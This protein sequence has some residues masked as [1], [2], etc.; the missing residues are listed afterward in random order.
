MTR[1]TW[2]RTLGQERGQFS[3]SLDRPAANATWADY[4][5]LCKIRLVSLVLFTTAVGFL[6][7]HTGAMNAAA[8]LL[9]IHTVLGTALVACGS[10]AINQVMERDTDGLMQ[11]TS[12]RPVPSGRVGVVEA[13]TFGLV[14]SLLGAVYLLLLVN[15]LAAGLVVLT[16]V[17][18]LAAYTPLKRLST[19][20]TLVGAVSG[21]IP[22]MI[23]YVAAA[24]EL[25]LVA[26]A[27]FG[28]LFVWQVPHF[29][30]IAWMYREDYARAG[31]QMLPVVDRDG[32]LTARQIVLFSLLLLV[33]SLMPRL[34][35]VAGQVYFSAALVFGLAFI[36]AGLPL[37]IYRDRRSARQVFLASVI[38]L[39]LLLVFLLGDQT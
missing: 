22:P 21:A 9:L 19:L 25:S 4:V 34:L 5:E 11:R 8:I 28:I 3:T 7:G 32:A 39:P 38:Y 31:L 12:A 29:L 10:M 2:P 14:L 30:G 35:A 23:G 15:A 20:N 27:L 16:S 33:V 1:I 17:V 26:W 24:G 37:L 6:I 18:Y 13:W 36:L